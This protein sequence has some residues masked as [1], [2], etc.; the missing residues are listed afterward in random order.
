VQTKQSHLSAVMMINQ[1]NQSNLF[2]HND[3]DDADDDDG[4]ITIV[5]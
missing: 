3:D 4:R 1:S 5:S 2:A